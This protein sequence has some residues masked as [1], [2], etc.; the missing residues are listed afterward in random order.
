MATPTAADA[1][2]EADVDGS[3]QADGTRGVNAGRSAIVY[4]TGTSAEAVDCLGT[5]CNNCV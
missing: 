3:R 5:V 1:I 4:L 2:A